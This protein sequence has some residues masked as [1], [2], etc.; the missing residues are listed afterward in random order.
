MKTAVINEV[1]HSELEFQYCPLPGAYKTIVLLSVVVEG[2]W[3][4]WGEWSLCSIEGFQ[5]RRRKCKEEP[6]VGE[7]LQ[8]KSCSCEGQLELH[9]EPGLIPVVIWIA[10]SSQ[11][12][13]SARD[14]GSRASLL[15]APFHAQVVCMVESASYQ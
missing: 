7:R 15:N 9:S 12:N 14:G 13:W 11:A 3:D 4:R 6:C 1:K 10:T 8:E 5:I 2:E